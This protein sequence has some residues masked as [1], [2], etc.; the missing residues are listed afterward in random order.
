MARLH[1]AATNPDQRDRITAA[2]VMKPGKNGK[3]AKRVMVFR[4]T[5]KNDEQDYAAV[6]S[7]AAIKWA[8]SMQAYHTQ[9]NMTDPVRDERISQ[10]LA[11]LARQGRNIHVTDETRAGSADAPSAAGDE[12]EVLREAVAAASDEQLSQMR[13]TRW[14]KYS[15]TRSEGARRRLDA[16]VEI[17]DAELKRR[18]EERDE[19]AVSDASKLTDDDIAAR[20]TESQRERGTYGSRKGEDA[21]DVE[22]AIYAERR[23]RSQALIDDDTDPATLDDTEL[24]RVREAVADRTTLHQ[25]AGD[26]H[27]AEQTV[28]QALQSRHDQLVGEQ[29]R[30]RAWQ[31]ADRPPVAELD[32]AA[33]EEEYHDLLVRDFRKAPP[34]A[35]RVLETRLEDL[36]REKR[37]RQLRGVTDRE[38][39]ESIDSAKLLQEYSELKKTHSSYDETDDIKAAR[40]ERAKA[41]QA[42]LDRRDTT[43][44]VEKLLARVDNPDSSGPIS[45]NGGEGYGYV[46]YNS[47][48]GTARTSL[49][50]TWGTNRWGHGSQ[51]YTSR[52]AAL[53]AMVRAYDNDDT[54]RGE[55]TWG[56]QRRVFV[57]KMFFELYQ[58]NRRADRLPS[59]S[60]E[61]RHLYEQFGHRYGWDDGVNPLVP[62][63]KKGR[64]IKGRNLA[65]PEGL[66]AELNRVTEELARQV[67]V[68]ATDREADS[69]DRSKAKTRLA[70]INVALHEIETRREAVRKNGGN[71]DQKVISREEIEAQQAAL[72]AALGGD[73]D[74]HVQSDGPGTLADAP[75][76]GMGG[77][78]RSGAVRDGEGPGDR[79][80]DSGGRGGTGAGSTGTGGVSGGGRPDPADQGGRD[81]DGPG[82]ASAR[83]GAGSGARAGAD[84]DGAA[85]AG[86]QGPDVRRVAAFRPDPADA[87]KGPRAR[88]AANV[89]AIK[90]LKVLEAGSRPAT[91]EEKRT[92]ARWSG[93]GSVPIIFATEPNAKEP[94]YQQGGTRHGKFDRDHERWA[95]Y[96]DVRGELQRVLTPIEFRQAS[97]GVLSMHYTPQPIASAM[98]D[99]LRAF[100]FDRGDVLEAGSGAGTFFGVA[101]DGARLTGVELDPTTARIAQAIY[102]RANV[103]NESFAET[104]ARP[105]T[106]DA[107]IGNV[108]FARVPFDDKRYPAESLHN[109]FVTKEIALVRPG[110]IT[111]VITTR[112]TLDSKGDKARRKMAQYG[113][114]VGAVRLPSGVFNDA[115]TGVTT[116]VLVFRRRGDGTEPADTGWLDAPERDINGTPH[117]VNAY[118]DEHPEHILG[119]LTTQSGPYGPEVTVKGDAAKAAEQLREAL[120]DIATKAKADGRGY[121]PHPDGDDRPRVQ[122]QTAR[123]KHAN[124]WTGRLYEGDDG[125]FYQH[126]NGA[127]PVHLE[128]ADGNTAQLR[129]LMR[130]RDVA[131]E[132]RELDRKND[133]EERAEALR[134]ELRDLHTLYVAAHGPLSKP[135]QHRTKSGRPTAWGY[136]RADPDAGAVLAL[137]R[138]DAKADEPVL[139]RVFT[140]RAAAAGSR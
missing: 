63:G 68:Q 88:A 136:F 133:E 56:A 18:R 85:P 112:Q 53:A 115:G 124:D 10:V 9:S 132:L 45:I 95:A 78:G 109:G 94:R 87:P 83:A 29:Q 91:D 100:G 92:L 93:W 114:L 42:E 128:P 138:W 67:S 40:L 117:H 111:A 130:L 66:L 59:A 1:Q 37:E 55:R 44:E 107:A 38:A 7:T 34:E 89:E 60:A 25:A 69:A 129:D 64:N 118:F 90:V 86:D 74:E 104:D 36:K 102:P 122:L 120:Q 127:E 140:E 17:L 19:T 126:V 15:R 98:W 97:R 101:P 26:D 51:V 6:G 48:V 13:S 113:D 96:S 24:T 57:P 43:P 32:E 79:D 119:E 105:G 22:R 8:P 137:E 28:R 134:A 47:T 31:I 116:D 3:P 11:K 73:D 58:D 21:N 71:D 52:A 50:W 49:G 123:E 20:I 82:R 72:R 27:A 33:L 62:S 99:G 14:G 103:L 4:G 2:W 61:R 65:I 75:A 121:E 41:I 30:R 46:D 23:R 81:G 39:P 108:P 12:T 135:G 5:V 77:D 54:R 139:S 80:A 35:Q 106:F 131:A 125:Q 110:G 16:E 84:A 76:A 70:S